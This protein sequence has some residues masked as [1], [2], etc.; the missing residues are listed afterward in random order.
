MYCNDLGQI[1]QRCW[2]EIPQ[3]FA[4]VLLDPIDHFIKEELRIPGYVRYADDL[5][6]FADDPEQLRGARAKLSERLAGLRLRLHRNKTMLAPCAGRLRFLGLVLERG[7]RRLQHEAIRRFNRRTRYLRWRFA[8]NEIGAA[9]I[10]RSLAAWTAFA[11]NA[12]SQGVRRDLWKRMRFRR[13]HPQ[14]D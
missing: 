13:S 3:H 12:N 10:G 4:N 8:R 1:A 14:V 9:A 7:G 6:L 11:E 5:V 2:E